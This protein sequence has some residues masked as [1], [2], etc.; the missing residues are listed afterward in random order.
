MAET[1]MH[2]EILENPR[3]LSD[4]EEK[5]KEKLI[6]ITNILKERGTKHVTFAARGTSDHASIYGQ[7]LMTVLGGKISA[8]AVP[9]ALTVYGAEP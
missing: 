3:I 9:S 7:Y 8:L 1:K 6:E 2:S 5:N 4:L